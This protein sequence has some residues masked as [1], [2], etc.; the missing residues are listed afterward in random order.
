MW[1][2]FTIGKQSYIT[3]KIQ[4]RTKDYAL[5]NLINFIASVVLSL[6]HTGEDAHVLCI[7][8]QINVNA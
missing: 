7:F 5:E 8:S 2:V 6:F 4:D 3:L 1:E